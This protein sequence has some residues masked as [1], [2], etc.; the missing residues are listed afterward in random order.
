VVGTRGGSGGPGG[1][2]RPRLRGQRHHKHVVEGRRAVGAAKHEQ[3]VATIPAARVP[4]A[5]RGRRLQTDRQTLK[6]CGGR[7]EDTQGLFTTR[8]PALDWIWMRL[9]RIWMRVPRIRMIFF[10]WGGG[11][12]IQNSSG[13]K[14]HISTSES[15]S[16][17]NPN[18]D[19]TSE[20]QHPKS[21]WR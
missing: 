6:K 10:L 7:S 21:Q 2:P 5:W 14:A 9:Q 13:S 17:P 8:G 11:G 12:S 18:G 3:L 20:L 19:R 1:H 15:F 4:I 16:T